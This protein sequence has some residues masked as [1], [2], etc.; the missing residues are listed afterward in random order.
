MSNQLT[1]VENIMYY[2]VP[3]LAISLF[4]SNLKCTCNKTIYTSLAAGII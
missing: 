2:G 3:L 4:F 1:K